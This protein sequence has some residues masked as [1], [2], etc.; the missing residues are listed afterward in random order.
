M[1]LE[2]SIKLGQ[3][4]R[5]TKP[6]LFGRVGPEWVVQATFRGIDGLWHARVYLASD[7]SHTK[8]LSTSVL[9]DRHHFVAG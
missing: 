3:R 9:S 1:T 4:F 5:D 2:P 6:G 7:S 8:T